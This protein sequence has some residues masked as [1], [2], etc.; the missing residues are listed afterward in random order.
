MWKI[1]L[2]TSK[3]LFQTKGKMSENVRQFFSDKTTIQL[4]VNHKSIIAN[5]VLFWGESRH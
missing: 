5:P 2:K 1:T 3:I 4:T